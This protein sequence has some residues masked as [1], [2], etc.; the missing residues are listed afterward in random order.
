MIDLIHSAYALPENVGCAQEWA[1]AYGGGA[2]R[3]EALRAHGCDA[4]RY[5]GRENMVELGVRAI[6]RL[7]AESGVA[8]TAV[9]ALIVF[10]TSPCNALPM[11]FT[12]TGA[13]RDGAGLSRSWAL[14]IGQQ[15]CVSPVHALRVLTALFARHTAW[16][17]AILVGVDTILREELRAIGVAGLHSDAASAM[18]IGRPGSGARLRAVE[19]YN[20]PQTVIGIDAAGQYRESPNYLWALISV[21][22]RILRSSG[23]PVDALDSILPHNVNRPAWQQ[24]LAAIRL[25]SE[26]LYDANFGRIGHAFGSD[27]AINLADS[28]ALRR[29]GRHLV[30][31]SGIGGCFGGFLLETGELR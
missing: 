9:D 3:G 27:A 15:H 13:L 14:S 1:A 22:R 5:L 29:A 25:P 2:A 12:L 8:R 19:T 7:I 17:H 4:Y 20:D 11:P 26:R 6:D 10:Q 28:G 21:I 16:R 18:L 24:A 23:T 31:A 30:F